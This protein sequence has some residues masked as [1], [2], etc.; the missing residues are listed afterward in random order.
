MSNITAEEIKIEL[1]KKFINPFLDYST[2]RIDI[3][4]ATSLC[5]EDCIKA[6][7]EHTKQNIEALINYI[8]ND[9]E[10]AVPI[11]SFFDENGYAIT[12]KEY[13]K[14]LLKILC[15]ELRNQFLENIK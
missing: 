7:Q 11:E 9:S 14:V 6:M 8:E 3:F 4:D 12:K 15:E 10:I 13:G 2:G 5:V 1:R